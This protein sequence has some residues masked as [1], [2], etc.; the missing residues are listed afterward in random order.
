MILRGCL[1]PGGGDDHGPVRMAATMDINRPPEE[2]VLLA[3]LL[4]NNQSNLHHNKL[5]EV[6]EVQTCGSQGCLIPGGGDHGDSAAGFPP[7]ILNNNYGQRGPP[8][9]TWTT[10]GG[11]AFL[12]AK[13]CR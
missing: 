10:A 8:E 1:I 4:N 13:R 2:T 6:L 12:R 5:Q 9:E 11:M 7:P 3:F